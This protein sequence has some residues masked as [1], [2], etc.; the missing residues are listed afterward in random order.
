[1][2]LNCI[3]CGHNNVN[4]VLVCVGCGRQLG[5]SAQGTSADTDA[6][7]AWD[8]TEPGRDPGRDPR[9]THQAPP[10]AQPGPGF[11]E[12]PAFSPLEPYG[13]YSA[14][15]PGA[16]QPGPASYPEVADAQSKAKTAMILGILGFFLVCVNFILG[17]IALYNGL[18]ARG[19]LLRYGVQEGQGMAVAG[20]VLGTVDILVALLYLMKWLAQ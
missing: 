8:G 17:P 1:M 15:W 9:E 4:G 16:W 5:T 20:I 19:V 14:P 6:P 2:T 12:P 10:S 13:P 3:Y 7:R 11:S 18:K